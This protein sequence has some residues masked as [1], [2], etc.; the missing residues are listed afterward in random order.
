MHRA[1]S[2]KIMLKLIGRT[3]SLSAGALPEPLAQA[4]GLSFKNFIMKHWVP[5]VRATNLRKASVHFVL[6]ARTCRRTPRT[7][8]F[9]RRTAVW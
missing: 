9:R 5:D 8:A 7:I 1:N 6:L 4:V 3:S 2:Q